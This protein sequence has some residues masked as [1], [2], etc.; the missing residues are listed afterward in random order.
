MKC[1]ICR[2]GDTKRGL[3]TITFTEGGSTLVVKD[4]PAQICGTCGEEYIDEAIGRRLLELVQ[5][6]AANGVEVDVR[7]FEAA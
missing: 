7:R 3:A 5:E 2:T 6:V 4:V 1:V